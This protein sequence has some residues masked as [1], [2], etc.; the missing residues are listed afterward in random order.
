[1]LDAWETDSGLTDPNGVTLPDLAAMGADPMRKDLF[2]EVGYMETTEGVTYGDVP[3]DPH[4]HRPTPEAL[5][6][7]GDAFWCAGAVPCDASTEEPANRIHVHFDVGDAYPVYS[8][9]DAYAE[10]YI[11]RGDLARGGEAIDET[12]TVCPRVPMVD[13]PEGAVPG[14]LDPWVCQFSEYLSCPEIFNTKIHGRAKLIRNPI[15]G[16]SFGGE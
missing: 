6:M 14:L 4:T 1:M 13:P 15:Y 7:V 2:V 11:L 16:A 8:D 10:R 5:K 3:M 12:V 9:D